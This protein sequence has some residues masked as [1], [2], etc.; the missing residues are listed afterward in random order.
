MATTVQTE[1]LQTLY[2][3]SFRKRLQTLLNETSD[4]FQDGFQALRLRALSRFEHLGFPTRRLEAWKYINVRP[5][6]NQAFLPFGEVKATLTREDLAAHLLDGD[7]VAQLVFVNGQFRAELSQI[8]ANLPKDVVLGS[9]KTVGQ[10]AQLAQRLESLL[11]EEADAFAA[12]NAA[13]FED[14]AVVSIPENVTVEPLVQLLFVSAPDEHARAAYTRNLIH[15]GK[16]AKVNLAISHLSLDETNATEY[17]NSSVQEFI[18]AEGAEAEC[19]IVFNESAKGWH[20]AA[21]RNQLAAEA[22]LSINTVTLAGHVTRHSITSLLQGE[23]AEVHLNGLDVL[24]DSTEVYHHTVS[25]HWVPDCISNQYYK[26]ILDDQSKS[27]F[28]GMVFVAEGANGT[29]SQQLNKNLLLSG[30]ARV[31]TRPQL[32]INAD[33]VKCAHGATVGQLDKNQ[34][35]YLASRGLDFELAQGL[36]TYGFAEEIIQRIG[37]EPLRHYLDARV[38]N[39]LHKTSA[40]VKQKIGSG[41]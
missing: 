33:D 37:S 2:E 26:G 14:G 4:G 11:A 34:L 1:S 36:L 12:L 30:D 15:L 39:N 16:N 24:C 10:E 20:L 13:L 23:K 35:F 41:K 8:P 29:D 22:K 38:L 28:N 21:T 19:S 27:E 31:W 25:E 17:F 5:L 7:Q 40:Q 3:Q 18:L 32:Q 6:L 9:V